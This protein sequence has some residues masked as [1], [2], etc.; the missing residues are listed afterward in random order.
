MG[1]NTRAGVPKVRASVGF[2]KCLGVRRECRRAYVRTA[3]CLGVRRGCG[4]AGQ[5]ECSPEGSIS[6][7]IHPPSLLVGDPGVSIKQ[8]ILFMRSSSKTAFIFMHLFT[9]PRLRLLQVRVI[10]VGIG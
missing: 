4:R 10:V 8:F 3:S 9:V 1:L 2:A 6:S 7:G 5:A